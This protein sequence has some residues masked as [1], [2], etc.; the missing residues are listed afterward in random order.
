MESENKD[1]T[2][3]AVLVFGVCIF[4]AGLSLGFAVDVAPEDEA[5]GRAGSDNDEINNISP[6][7]RG[8]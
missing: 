4:F 6:V 1:K 2:N 7:N 8:H 5:F 3:L